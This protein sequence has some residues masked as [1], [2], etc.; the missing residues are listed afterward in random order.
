M[1]VIQNKLMSLKRCIDR[2]ESKGPIKKKDITKNYDLQDIVA[3]NL[4]RAIQISVD[5]A[6]YIISKTN[7]S[8]VPSTMAQSFQILC[9]NK[10]ISNEIAKKMQKNICFRNIAIHE[11]T[12][13]D[14]NIIHSITTSNINDF[15][16]YAIEIMQWA[17]RQK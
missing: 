10:I 7:S 16:E 2:I 11:Y 17:K 12:A 9:D 5:I 4:Q 15:R 6:S 13:L 14:W 8:V 1:N 3:L